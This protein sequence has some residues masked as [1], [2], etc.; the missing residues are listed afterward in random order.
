ML[1]YPV[2]RG[3]HGGHPG[4]MCGW[5]DSN[6]HAFRHQFLRLE[7]L[8]FHHI[9]GIALRPLLCRPPGAFETSPDNVYPATMFRPNGRNK[10]WIASDRIPNI[11]KGR[12]FAI[13]LGDRYREIP[14]SGQTVTIRQWGTPVAHRYRSACYICRLCDSSKQAFGG[15]IGHFSPS[16]V[17]DR[18]HLPLRSSTRLPAPIPGSS[19]R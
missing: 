3:L 14:K 6:P 11:R 10:L 19:F 1:P 13:L 5:R 9:R 2:F 18:P 17:S 15:A 12:P 4:R 8:P 7:C 16:G